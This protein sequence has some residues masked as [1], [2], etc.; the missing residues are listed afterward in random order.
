MAKAKAGRTGVADAGQRPLATAQRQLLHAV[1]GVAEAIELRA[2]GSIHAVEFAQNGRKLL[3]KIVY[4]RD[5]AAVDEGKQGSGADG[6][7]QPP[8][9]PEAYRADGTQ[10]KSQQSFWHRLTTSG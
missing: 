2:P 8:S 1:R 10:A 9:A 5:R 3:A 7:P 4:N 6:L